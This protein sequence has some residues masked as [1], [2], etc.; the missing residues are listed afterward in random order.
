[1][2]FLIVLIVFIG[3][4]IIGMVIGHRIRNRKNNSN[5]R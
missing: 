4:V 3:S 2:R 1:M 5:F